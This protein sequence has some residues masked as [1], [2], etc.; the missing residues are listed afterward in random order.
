M[1]NPKNNFWKLHHLS[2]RQIIITRGINTYSLDLRTLSWSRCKDTRRDRGYFSACLYKGEI[3][4]LST[5]SLVAAGTVEKYNIL[6]DK[7]S[8]I[9]SLPTRLRS[10]ASASFQNQSFF[11]LGGIESFR[12]EV[13]NCIYILNDNFQTTKAFSLSKIAEEFNISDNMWHD[14]GISL[15]RPRYRHA[16]IEFQNLIWIAGGCYDDHKVTN[17]VE[18]YDPFLKTIKKGPPM[19]IR[20]DFTNLLIVGT[21]L[22]AVGGDVDADEVES[23]RTIE[24]FNNTENRWKFVTTFKSSRRG[25]STSAV[26][27]KIFVFGGIN[28]QFNE[29]RTWDAYNTDSGSWDSD[30]LSAESRRM[31]RIDPWGQAVSFPHSNVK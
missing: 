18:L 10:V 29:D 2:K 31:P 16:A 19:L 30:V 3:Y 9:A 27:E 22:Y 28:S 8:A 7:W 25:F 6:L 23:I 11:A 26:N 24:R 21:D 4:A 20:R 15:L 14:V 17:E 12:E 5:Y 1:S 13:S